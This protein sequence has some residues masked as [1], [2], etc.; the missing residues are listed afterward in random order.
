[1]EGLRWKEEKVKVNLIVLMID[2]LT[3]QA[4]Q[5]RSSLELAGDADSGLGE[6][7]CFH[8]FYVP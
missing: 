8:V 4:R 5:S 2:G 1:M 7:L 6:V 3:R